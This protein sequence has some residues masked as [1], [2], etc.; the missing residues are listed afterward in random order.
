MNIIKWTLFIFVPVSLVLG[1]YYL[2]RTNVV[3]V[4]IGENGGLAVSR[5]LQGMLIT[6]S[7]TLDLP[8]ECSQQYFLL[9]NDS[10]VWLIPKYEDRNSWP[11]NF[12]VFNN[13]WVEIVGSKDFSYSPCMY[14]VSAECGCDDYI[15]VD[16]IKIVYE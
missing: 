13:N 4:K 14:R 7:E 2:S 6:G 8:P 1:L 9:A 11:E 5:K 3:N 10:R 15:I 16:N 12:L